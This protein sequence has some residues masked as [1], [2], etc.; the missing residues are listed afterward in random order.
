[1]LQD[2]PSSDTNLQLAS[3]V[4]VD[5]HEPVP[6]LVGNHGGHGLVDLVHRV[7]LDPWLD[8]LVGCKLEHVAHDGGR[9]DG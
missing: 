6:S 9:T 4:L 7:L 5:E 1:M 2:R 8:V 3:V